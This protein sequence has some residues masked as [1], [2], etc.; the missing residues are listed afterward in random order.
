MDQKVFGAF[1]AQL[2]KEQNMTQSQL[3]EKLH[4]TDKAVSKWET[5]RGL[6]DLGNLETLA[7]VLDVTVAELLSCKK[8]AEPVMQAE[9]VK[10]VLDQA[11]ELAEYKRKE[12]RRK[13]FRGFGFTA[14]GLLLLLVG[15]RYYLSPAISFSIIGGK[16][17]PTSVFVA[18]K[19]SAPVP[20]T[21]MVLGGVLLAT[22]LWKLLRNK[23]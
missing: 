23:A 4:V 14:A 10:A 1:I 20:L 21:A 19:L 6:P 7:E 22:G 17:G 5:G 18:G 15:L 3:A 9:E 13:W 2:R 12:A 11:F 8:Q 16:D